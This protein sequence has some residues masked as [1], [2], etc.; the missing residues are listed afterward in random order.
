MRSSNIFKSF[1]KK[2]CGS[3]SNCLS[4]NKQEELKQKDSE[5]FFQLESVWQTRKSLDDIEFY[6]T[7]PE[8]LKKAKRDLLFKGLKNRVKVFWHIV[9]WGVKLFMPDFLVGHPSAYENFRDFLKGE[10]FQPLKMAILSWLIFTLTIGGGG[11]YIL[12]NPEISYAD[13]ATIDFTTSGDY[14]ISNTDEIEVVGD[15][16]ALKQDALQTGQ[17][18]YWR[19][20][21]TTPY[22]GTPGEVSDLTG[23]GNDGQ[24]FNGL[25]QSSVDPKI[26]KYIDLNGSNQ[27]VNFTNLDLFGSTAVSLSA[28]VR[29]DGAINTNRGIV[30]SWNAGGQFIF[31]TSN[32]NI[33]FAVGSG[34][35]FKFV[36]SNTPISQGVWYNIVGVWTG[37]ALNIYINGVLSGQN[38]SAVSV[39]PNK[40]LYRDIGRF[41]NLYYMNGGVDEV[42]VWNK[43]LTD[44][45]VS[46]GQATP[47]GTEVNSLYNAGDGII[48]SKYSKYAPN[49]YK[50]T[51]LDVSGITSFTGFS[52]SLGVNNEGSVEYQIATSTDSTP[53]TWSYYNNGW[54]PA[55]SDSDRNTATT[56]NTNISGLDTTGVNRVFVKAFL[57]SDGTQQ[58][59]IDSITINYITNNNP[60]T[61][62]NS[63]PTHASTTV[64]LHPTLSASAFSDIDD[65]D[66]HAN[67]QWQIDV[68]GGD[69]S[70]PV[71]DSGAT[72]TAR[73]SVI[74]QNRLSHNTDYDWRVRYQDDSGG[75][76]AYSNETTFTTNIIE[77]PS[78]SSPK[79]GATVSTL[80][81]LLEG[82]SFAD[83]EV[84]H[85]HQAT[86]WQVDDSSDF[87]SLVWE[88]TSSSAETSY[89]IP[90]VNLANLQT[91]SWRVRYQD[92]ID[93]WSEWSTGTSFTV[94]IPVTSI[95]INPAFG[96][97]TVDQGDSVNIDIQLLNFANGT[98]MSD[99]ESV[100]VDIYNPS[101]TKLV[102]DGEMSYISGSS[103]LYRYSYT[104]PDTSG[105]Y[106]YEVVAEK[107]GNYGYGAANF[108]VRTISADITNTL[109]TLT[110]EIASSTEERAAQLAERIAQEAE[111]SAQASERLAQ[112]TERAAQLE[113]RNEVTQILRDVN[114]GILNMNKVIK[115]GDTIPFKFRAESGL[116]GSE[117]PTIRVYDAGFNPRVQDAV[118]VES[119]TEAGIYEYDVTFDESWG[120]GYFTVAISET[121]NN[122][123]EDIQIFVSNYSLDTISAQI[124]TATTSII[125][126]INQNEAKLDSLAQNLDILLGAMIVTQST[127]VDSSPTSSSFITDLINDTTDFYTDAVITFNSGVLNGQ[128]RRISGYNATTKA[129]TVSPSLSS[130]PADNDTF[131]IVKQNVYVQ[132]QLED[133]EAA[134]SASRD[135]IN[136]IDTRTSEIQ[137]T[138]EDTNTRVRDIESVVNQTYTLLQ[139]VDTNLDTIDNVIDNIRASQQSFYEVELS[140]VDTI[141][142]E[143]DYRARLTIRDFEGDLANANS[144]PEI[145]IYDASRDVAL[146]TTTMTR[147]STGIYEYVYSVPSDATTGLWET[148]VYADVGGDSNVIR[149]DYWQVSGSPAQVIINSMSDLTVPEVSA[150]VTI[151]NEGSA[152]YEY[153]YEWCVVAEQDNQ[154]GGN[155][156][157]YHGSAAK[158]IQPGQLFTK[159][160]TA[161]IS[162][163][164]DYW[165]KVSVYF[166]SQVSGASRYFS[167][168][169]ESANNTTIS[170][171]SGGGIP[172]LI[173]IPSTVGTASVYNEVVQMRKQMEV[174]S[175][176]LSQALEILGKI[177]PSAPGFKTVLEISQENTNSLKDIQ[178]KVSDLKAVSSTLKKI[179][180]TQANEPI[181]ETYMKFNSVEINFLI[182]N[183]VSEQQLV[184]FKAFLPSE[185]RP[186][187]ILDASG[188]KVDYDP[189][190]GAYYVHAE[191]TM[192]PNESITRKVEM[193]DIWEFD[194][195]ELN[196][197]KSQAQEL[198]EVLS[199]TQYNSQG[200]ILKNAIA[201]DIEK[202]LA[203]QETSYSS[204]QEHIVAFREN[205]S[206]YDGVQDNF[207][208]LSDLVVQAGASKG[209]VGSIGG[210]QTFAVWGIILAMVFGFGLLIA[211]VFAMWR[212][213]TSLAAQA[214]RMSAPRTPP[215]GGTQRPTYSS[216]GSTTVIRK[217]RGL[218]YR[219]VMAFL[220][221]AYES[222]YIYYPDG[223]VSVKKNF[224]KQK[225]ILERKALIYS[226]VIKRLIN[227]S[228]FALIIALVGFYLFRSTP[229]LMNKI[230]LYLEENNS[231][232]L[233]NNS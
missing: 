149:N 215:R 53:G 206:R 107:D 136:A 101:G 144:T 17:Q 124:D 118:M 97:V 161:T 154:C 50:T 19:F 114:S 14:T 74:S 76:S 54:V 2:H 220:E 135:T 13:S 90:S 94:N 12:L 3:F 102:D 225:M 132:K 41:D 57:I 216:G 49:I 38:L 10:H 4:M 115:K 180:E 209:L 32:N 30:S 223:R 79:H 5:Y 172:G 227:L 75:W 122:T 200:I 45:S 131:T 177:N 116:T 99:A 198:L 168:V 133:H 61:P 141:Q 24:A 148:L 178:N 108:E 165:F 29:F 208:K 130:A 63:F 77:T 7:H 156:D 228:L 231:S 71:W 8:E 175:S 110:Q 150:N 20:D 123:G 196:T 184:K 140:E 82:S 185:A 189:N 36:R 173:N 35:D 203:R 217:K 129:I 214:M 44:G 183:P 52:D 106:L 138:V 120:T 157:I 6:K 187:H 46:V 83:E 171:V 96:G 229:Y 43:A 80:T 88:R 218:I 202:I 40:T 33:N 191:I 160:L 18:A 151:Q 81:P 15:L 34:S 233:E 31:Y 197:L 176:K 39:V 205:T 119:G 170:T 25:V 100:V 105:S 128:T 95:Q 73:T 56:I 42:S 78:N 11:I 147:L 72:S 174:E 199:G 164:G 182:T 186:E 204:P 27:Y 37:T 201:T 219:L 69:F 85:T 60:D 137:D 190:A 212:H 47:V 126:E 166:G 125:S 84:G 179:V 103:G 109:N 211:V 16:A 112:A 65:G 58:V 55:S 226:L 213:Q 134:Q 142:S 48:I 111:R 92:S 167:A 155:D 98:P 169:N 104:I 9:K 139:N 1:F 210:I 152:E 193:T 158:L 121:A 127:V 195:A 143:N 194:K 64:A 145:V 163:T 70:S 230:G 181:V 59:E 113:S 21:D 207:N 91:Y 188:L 86:Q 159:D 221:P 22:N 28:W 162:D 87:S 62:T 192:A 23:N 93:E 68:S 89:A 117:K 67:S 51:G 66:T 232:Q 26:G 224:E 146:A 153:Q 222:Q